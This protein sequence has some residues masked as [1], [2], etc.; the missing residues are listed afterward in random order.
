LAASGALNPIEMSDVRATDERLAPMVAATGGGIAWL[1]SEPAPEF[2][3]VRPG[4]TA[5]GRNRLSDQAW[6]GL[7]TNGDYVVTGIREIPLLPGLL[8]L[9]AALGTLVLAWRREGK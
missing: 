4:R 7:R 6:F 1:A 8:V 3:E 2:R 9:I 5:A